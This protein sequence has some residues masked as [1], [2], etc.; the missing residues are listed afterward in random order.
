MTRLVSRVSRDARNPSEKMNQLGFKS[1]SR[2]LP[3][4]RS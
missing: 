3:V 2:I 4:I 1:S